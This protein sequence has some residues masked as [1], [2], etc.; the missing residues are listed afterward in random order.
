VAFRCNATGL[1]YRAEIGA[2]VDN[3]HDEFRL[4][5]GP[6]WKDI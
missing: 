1:P 2:I 4:V 3:E 6:R 5:A